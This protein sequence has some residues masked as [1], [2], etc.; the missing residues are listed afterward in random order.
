MSVEEVKPIHVAKRR[1]SRGVDLIRNVKG[2]SL[3]SD[4]FELGP[5]KE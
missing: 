5:K 4:F 1:L 3:A 2:A